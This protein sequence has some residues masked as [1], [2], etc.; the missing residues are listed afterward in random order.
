VTGHGVF[1]ESNY[2]GVHG[3]TTNSGNYGVAG[4]NNAGGGGVLGSGT[5]GVRAVATSGIGVSASSASGPY[6]VTG[7]RSI[8]GTYGALGYQST[9]GIQTGVVGYSGDYN[10]HW[11]GDFWGSVYIDRNLY[12]IQNLY[13]SGEKDFMIDH[14]QDPSNKYLIHSCVESPDRM[15]IYN[16]KTTTDAQ[17]LAS[18]E[19]PSY[20]D[21]LNIEFRYQLTVIGQFAQAIVEREIENN[22]FV[23]RTDKPNVKV[24]WQVTGM[25]NDAYAKTHPMVVEKEKETTARGKYLMPKLFGQPEEMGI[26]YVK[27]IHP[28]DLERERGSASKEGH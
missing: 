8:G 17:G 1:G 4:Y 16:G 21:A 14:P 24:S 23:I 13:V 27:P 3:I 19:L 25:R 5:D 15:N 11:A 22:H 18:V 20:F 9:G 12:V 6:A 10:T 7:F 28:E 26:H 2:N